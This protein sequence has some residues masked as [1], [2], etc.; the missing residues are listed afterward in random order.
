[1]WAKGLVFGEL[2]KIHVVCT[3]IKVARDRDVRITLFFQGETSDVMPWILSN[4]ASACGG[5][6]V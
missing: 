1:M 2:F 5:W 6:V 3:T 4:I